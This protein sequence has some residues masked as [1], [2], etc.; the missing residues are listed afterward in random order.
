MRFTGLFLSVVIL[1]MVNAFSSANQSNG[2]WHRHN[3]DVMGT[4]ASIEF[5]L[6]DKTRANQLI[7][8]LVDEMRRVDSTMSPYIAT[9]E[10]SLIN[11]KAAQKPLKI[12]KELFALIKASIDFSE[13]TQ[14]AFDITFSSLGYLYD[15]PNK[16]KPNK[17]VIAQ[18]KQ[19]IDY[20]KIILNHKQQTIYFK[21]SR[22]KID[23]GGIAKGHAVDNCIT[24]LQQAGVKNAYINAGGDT[25]LL[26]KKDNRLWYIGIRNPR[27]KNK[28]LTNLPLEEV[29][30]STSGDYERFF[31]Q[32]GV[33]YHHIIDP[34]TGVSAKNV[35][36]VTILANNSLMADALSTSV[37]VLGVEDGLSLI[38]RLPDISAVIVDSQGKIWMSDDMTSI[39]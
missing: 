25:R 10:L 14:G 30:V 16:V 29:A 38:N 27:E 8:Q 6:A 31:V 2:Y 34:K 18:L 4:Q 22:I 28:L 11:Q 23:L 12:S 39:K 15:Y 33:R 21:D 13:L 5:E 17:A 24:I 37:F 3:F 1:F 7:Q 36:S 9:S 20:K 32:D 35:Q 19:A 26:G